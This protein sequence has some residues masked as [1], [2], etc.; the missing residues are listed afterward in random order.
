MAL[1]TQSLLGHLDLLRVRVLRRCQRCYG[2]EDVNVSVE[3]FKRSEKDGEVTYVGDEYFRHAMA[4]R[5][6][7]EE[8]PDIVIV[9]AEQVWGEYGG[10]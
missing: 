4:S 9:R 2:T 10:E 3:R 6:I 1:H 5:H 7:A 8:V